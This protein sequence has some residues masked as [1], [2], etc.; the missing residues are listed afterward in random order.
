MQGACMNWNYGR[1]RIFQQYNLLNQKYL[2]GFILLSIF[3]GG[4]VVLSQCFA[5]GQLMISPTRVVFEGRDRA[6]QINIINTGDA[7]ETYRISFI[8][9]RMTVNGNF[10][11]IKKG[12]AKDG[13]NFS[14]KMIRFSPRQVVLPPG[15]SQTI[16]LMLRRSKNIEVGEY[17]SHLYFKIIPKKS[18]KSIDKLVGEASKQVKIEL[19]PIIGVT[20][21]IIVRH[22]NTKATAQVTDLKLI[23]PTEKDVLTKV[24]LRISRQGNQSIYGDLTA[25]YISKNGDEQI[26][27][28]ANGVAVYT[29]NSHRN[30]ILPLNVESKSSF[31]EGEIVVTFR[32]RPDNGGALLAKSKLLLQ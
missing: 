9:K 13:E 25:T 32:E 19:T 18:S 30:V 1:Y 15:K 31:E 21:P 11:D 24:S 26:L 4:Q 7:T 23:L 12:E 2:M 6:A 14:S 28:R 16:R 5:G 27:G 29:P 8:E 22:G 17:R 3:F 20:I 10:I